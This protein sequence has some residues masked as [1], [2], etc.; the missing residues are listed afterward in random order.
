MMERLSN[1]ETEKNW[2]NEQLE[3][4]NKKCKEILA[5]SEQNLEKFRFESEEKVTELQ[6]QM[7]EMEKVANN[8]FFVFV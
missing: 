2:L 3:I 1:I 7:A 8:Y 6:T 4:A 5:E